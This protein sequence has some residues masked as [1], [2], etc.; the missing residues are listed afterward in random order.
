MCA[1]LALGNSELGEFEIGI[2]ICPIKYCFFI[3]GPKNPIILL[4]KWVGWESCQLG[5]T[6]T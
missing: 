5:E 2:F 1:K 6:I 3:I 4:A